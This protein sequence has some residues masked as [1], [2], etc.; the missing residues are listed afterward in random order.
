[1]SLMSGQSLPD[2]EYQFAIFPQGSSRS[3]LFYQ[4]RDLYH[5]D[6]IQSQPHWHYHPVISGVYSHLTL[7]AMPIKYV[8]VFDAGQLIVPL[9]SDTFAGE[10]GPDLGFNGWSRSCLNRRV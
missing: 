2:T 8:M 5:L 9:A 4:G 6:F 3:L 10:P 7:K 1:M